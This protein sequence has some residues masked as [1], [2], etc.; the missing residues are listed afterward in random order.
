MAELRQDPVSGRWVIIATERAARPRDFRVG[1]GRRRGGFCPFC[2]GNEGRTPPEIYAIRA[3]GTAPNSPGWQVRVVSNKFPALRPDAPLEGEQSEF[4]NSVGGR[5]VHEVIIESP[6][7]LVSPTEMSVED[8]ALGLQT[9]CERSRVLSA[10]PGIA[11]VLIFKNVGKEAG[12][13]IEHM[14]SQLIAI[15]VMPKRTMEEMRRCH[16]YYLEKGRC[17]FCAMVEWELER[18]ERTI[19]DREGFLVLSPYAARSPF[20]LCVLPK[21]HRAH[22]YDLSVAETRRLASVMQEALARLELCLGGP[23]FNYVIHTTPVA[24]SETKYYH[25]HIEVIPRITHLAGFELGTG[26]YINPMR[27]ESAAQHLR[28]VPERDVREAIATLSSPDT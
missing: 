17:L 5:G 25:W 23:P 26:F 21:G 16:D 3:Q 28:D 2:E 20:E 10:R 19:I 6:R 22:F 8:F 4:Y 11:Y 15:P 1:R 9:C 7:H 14:H 12:A 13:S 24:M 27:P 18:A